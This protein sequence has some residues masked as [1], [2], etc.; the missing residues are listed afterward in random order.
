MKIKIL[1]S[2]LFIVLSGKIGAKEYHVSKTGSDK[3]DGSASQPL[4]TISAAAEIANPGDTITVHAGIYRESV[5]PRR[6]GTS[7]LNR[8]LY[9]AATGDKVII[10]GSESVKNWKQVDG[11]LWKIVLPNS[12]FGDYNPYNDLITGDWFNHKGFKHHTGEVFLNGKALFEKNTLEDVKKSEPY[13]DALDKK[14]ST[15]TWFCQV[16][17]NNTTLWANFQGFDP[18][19]ELVEINVRPSCFYPDKPGVNYITVRGFIMDQAATQWAAPTA[20]QIGLVGT[21]WSKGWIIEHNVISNSK[22]VGV[23]LG[24]ERATGHN[25]WSHNKTKGGATHY[26]EVIFRAL[27]IGWSKEKIGS[28]I[29]RN[30]V[31][32]DCGQAGIVGS[33][34]AVYSKIHNNHIYDIWTRRTFAGA[35]MAGIKIHAPIDMLIAEN[36]IHNTGRGIW[37]DWMAQGTRITKNVLY[38]NTSDDLFTEVNHGPNMV[39]HN[40]FLSETAIKDWSESSA[41]AHNLIAGRIVYGDIP[42]RYTPY[43]LPH[44][45]KVAGLSNT[46]GGDNRFFNNIF[47]KQAYDDSK[48]HM[49]RIDAIF[50]GLQ[51]YEITKYEN[52]AR[53]NVYY[54]GA[55]PD[56]EELYFTEIP[57]DKPIIDLEEKDGALYLSIKI[58][59]APDRTKSAQVTTSLLGTTIISEAIYENANGTPMILDSDFPGNLR[60]KKHPMPGPFEALTKGVNTYL[61]WNKSD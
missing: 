26:N 3:N 27:E 37:I 44:S 29:V 53:G 47:I 58:K 7:D 22:C 21:H 24:K 12:F 32:Y 40:I 52:I 30:N 43:H 11:S 38:D 17:E 49:D 15:Y 39:D 50:Y 4:Q 51:G 35:E 33:L 20:E 1:L 54:N 2:A 6:G 34:G 61:V 19:Q 31:I 10:K 8:I 14:A 55:K 9:R 41:F 18:N 28:H 16:D 46:L 48:V 25:V 60:N 42:G 13:P 59:K 36:R 5:N 23:T 57:N 45:T 56:Q